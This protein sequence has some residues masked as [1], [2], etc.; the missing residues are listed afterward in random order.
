VIR[1][2]PLDVIRLF[3]PHD[4]SLPGLLESRRRANPDAPFMLFR[5]RTWSRGE[6]A[7]ATLRLA[8]GLRARGINA[9]DKVAVLSANHEA[10]V[11]L[12]FALARLNA[13]LV[14]V[15]PTVTS[16]ELQHVLSRTTV[17]AM[18]VTP[19]SVDV[20]RQALAAC[21][22]KAWL[23]DAVGEMTDLP[24]LAQLM[25]T[26][27][28]TE[29][30]VPDPQATCVIIFT[31]GSTGLPK[32]AMHSQR[33]FVLAGEA[34]VAR[35][36]LQ[37]ED[38]VMGIMPLFHTNAMFYSLAGA[39][40]AGACF[41]LVE[42]FSASTFWDMVVET[43]ATTVNIIE[44]IG[45]ILR[46]RPRSEFRPEHGLESVYGVRSDMADCFRNEFGVAKL[47]SGYGMTEIPGVCCVPWS[48][49]DKVGSMGF[50]GQHPDPD[51][52]WAEVRIVD[53]AGADVPDGSTGE[54][55]VRHPIVMQGYIGDE[56]QTR[57]TFQDGWF[58][59]GDLVRRDPD[60]VYWFVSRKKDVIR[61]RGENISGL[62]IDM[63]VAQ[64]PG[65]AEVAA[66]PVPAELGEDE[67]MVCVVRRTGHDP[68]EEDI[69]N[70][71]KGRLSAIKVPRYVLFMD[72]LP[73]SPT[74]KVQK[75]A[76]K[77]QAVELMTR[78]RD[79]QIG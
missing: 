19:E 28:A 2:P 45:R 78:A 34:N 27:G 49:L 47:I 32:G 42:K 64:H 46:A 29:L 58:K 40:A 13:T 6:F 79:F 54:I 11:L 20:A 36:W 51:M 68:S 60:G 44:A 57:A 23:L 38:R 55:W 18:A 76:L 9:G 15:N 25:E 39:V 1:R 65:V 10:H 63:V 3:E 31:S 70:W 24:S 30:P 66:I 62:E 72:S 77:A 73:H 14:P 7:E 16:P 52:K 69:R 8:A 71:C 59:T 48:G 75:Q 67:V 33:N 35:L 12:L 4:H 41:I 5:D 37:P 56:E 26:S 61:R 21:G 50:I 43:G 74:H 53:D 22:S 17:S